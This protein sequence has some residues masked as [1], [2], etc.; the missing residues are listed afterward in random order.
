MASSSSSWSDNDNRVADF[1]EFDSPPLSKH[2]LLQKQKQESMSRQQEA[3]QRCLTSIY[4][5]HSVGIA[6]AEE[7][8]RQGEQ[9]DNI[10]EKTEKINADTRVS[11]RHLNGIKSIFG[12]IKNWWQGDPSKDTPQTSASIRSQRTIGGMS[13]DE[14]ERSSS[15]KSGVH[16]AMRLRTDP[17]ASFYDDDVQ[18]YDANQS[19][20]INGRTDTGT[21]KTSSANQQQQSVQRSG[22][23]QQYESNLNKNLDAMSS[24]LG[25][26]KLLAEGLNVEIEAQNDQLDRIM[27]K[28]DRADTKIRD[29]N[30]QMRQI[31]G[32]DK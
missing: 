15:Q 12:G 11:Q 32:K 8:A 21:H 19:F 28:V 24:G 1:S 29:Q 30:R 26:L 16:P 31:L 4:D 10:E 9:L 22:E 3:T 25:H 23:W 27:P 5:S 2:E 14:L 17:S 7:L 20:N 6:T 13:R 18:T